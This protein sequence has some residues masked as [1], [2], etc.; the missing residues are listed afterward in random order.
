MN[1]DERVMAR[2]L[3]REAPVQGYVLGDG[4]YDSN[5]LHDVCL[6]REAVQFV[7]PRRYG[8]GRG[9]GH[10]PQSP[11]RL[12]SRELLEGKSPF[13]RSLFDQRFLIEQ[14]FGHLGRWSQQSP[15]VGSHSS[16]SPS[17]GSS[18]THFD[19][20]ETATLFNDLRRFM[21]KVVTLRVS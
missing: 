4:N 20:S 12:R 13:G 21:K 11:S 19:S 1:K 16:P 6:N 8:P 3:L 2:R 18:Q 17:L 15:T 9:T 10:R 5:D 14:H 7:S